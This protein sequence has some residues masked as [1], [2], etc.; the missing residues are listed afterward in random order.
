MSTMKEMISLEA[1]RI[2]LRRLNDDIFIKQYMFLESR[3]QP[4]ALE[5]PPLTLPHGT[6]RRLKEPVQASLLFLTFLSNTR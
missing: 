6:P 5:Y 4:E 2:D 1:G 3:P